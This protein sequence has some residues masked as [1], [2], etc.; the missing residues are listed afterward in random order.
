MISH[1]DDTRDQNANKASH[2]HVCEHTHTESAHD[3]FQGPDL[4]FSWD[5]NGP[6]FPSG[7]QFTADMDM[8]R[9]AQV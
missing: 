6:L 3:R 9:A 2:P 8:P 5:W 4:T 7:M 1:D